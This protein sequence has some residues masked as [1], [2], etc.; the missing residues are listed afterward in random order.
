MLIY[1]ELVS[2]QYTVEARDLLSQYQSSEMREGT[3][4]TKELLANE[5]RA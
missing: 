3:G 2:K 4:E 1:L 5:P